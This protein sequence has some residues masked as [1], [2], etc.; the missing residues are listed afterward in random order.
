MQARLPTICS[1]IRQDPPDP[2]PVSLDATM[3]ILIG[4]NLGVPIKQLFLDALEQNPQDYQNP[5]ASKEKDDHFWLA[6]FILAIIAAIL[7]LIIMPIL[8]VIAIRK[9]GRLKQLQSQSQTQ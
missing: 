7:I 8:F 1:I 4:M 6:F 9:Y 3:Y 2:L 5:E